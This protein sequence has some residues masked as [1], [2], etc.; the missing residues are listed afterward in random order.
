[1]ALAGIVVIPRH[2]RRVGSERRGLGYL[3]RAMASTP[4]QTHR[5][6]D[7]CGIREFRPTSFLFVLALLHLGS[8]GA[9]AQG[10]GCTLGVS[11]IACP[12]SNRTI[13][14]AQSGESHHRRIQ[15][16]LDAAVPGDLILVRA[17]TYVEPVI[18]H[19]SGTPTAPI[20]LKAFPGERPLI[21]P[22]SGDGTGYVDLRGDWLVVDGFD[23]SGGRHGIVVSGSH[24][25][26]RNAYVHDN[27]EGCPA[28]QI[29]GQGVMVASA[30]DVVI[31]SNKIVRNGLTS[32]SPWHVHGIYLSGYYGT[33][34]AR[35]TILGNDIRSH[36]GAGIQVWDA[37][38]AES[39]LVRGNTFADNAIDLILSNVRNTLVQGNEFSHVTHPQ[40]NAP[41]SSLLW[42]EHA[43]AVSIED[44]SF[45]FN[46]QDQLG[47]PSVPIHMYAADQDLQ[48]LGWR[49]NSWS[50]PLY[51]HLNDAYLSSFRVSP[52]PPSRPTLLVERGT[53]N[54]V[55]LSWS[56]GLGGRVT[57]YTL[58]VG[59]APGRS[60]LATISLGVEGRLTAMAP[61][62][63]Q[64]FVS[65]VAQNTAGRA[66]S[67]EVLIRA[68]DELVPSAP[69]M[70]PAIVAGRTVR[71]AWIAEPAGSFTVI[72]RD[73]E[74]G[75]VIA[76]LPVAGGATVLTLTDVPPGSYSVSVAASN[77]GARSRESS[78]IHVNVAMP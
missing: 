26:V 4:Q 51:P 46:P 62:G 67:N 45:T 3:E 33:A 48:E 29:C 24:N 39:V 69:S 66:V 78:P 74:G 50:A 13:I 1:M 77:G 17:G 61:P 6:A 49:A 2:V 8:V 31:E 5:S 53:T 60:D 64:L 32:I 37:L 71:L 65:V 70:L 9:L 10:S 40:T 43:Y 18:L 14:V 20:T 30:S 21:R 22:S 54:P 68:A 25:T 63:V 15:P 11:L 41:R 23:V 58:M 76:S 34:T 44:N 12:G 16:A 42:L 73:H 35:V 75:A 57:E 7:R 19:V 27:G 47:V 72:A 55:T 56:A 38:T 52:P 36:G 59:S 28:N